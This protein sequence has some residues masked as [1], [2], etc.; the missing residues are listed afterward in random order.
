MLQ[1]DI[2]AIVEQCEVGRLLSWEE[3]PL[4]HH[5]APYYALRTE[6]GRYF[7]KRYEHFT[8]N[9]D[10]GLDLITYLAGQGYPTVRVILNRGRMPHMGHDDTEVALFEFIDLPRTT[11]PARAHAAA[12][13]DALGWLH[14]TSAPFPIAD[15]FLGHAEFYRR[16][17]ALPDLSWAPSAAREALSF[18]ADLFPHLAASVRA[19]DAPIRIC[20][21]EFYLEHLRFDGARLAKVIDWDLVGLDHAFHDLGTTMGEWVSDEMDFAS[22][23]ALLDAYEARRPLTEWERGH[24]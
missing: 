18:M 11:A 5:N 8:P 12:I 3:L 9:V 16:F 24:L 17:Q 7:L 21:Q 14:A 1:K 20:H 4:R 10:A 15:T 13:G 19:G 22:L 23:G 2:D 6:C